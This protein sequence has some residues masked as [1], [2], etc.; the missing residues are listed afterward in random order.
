M[1]HVNKY[2]IVAKFRYENLRAVRDI[3]EEN[4]YF[5]TFDLKSDYH[6]IPIAKEHQKDLGFAWDFSA[7]TRFFVFVVLPFGLATAG[8]AFTKVMRSLKKKW[9]AEGK[10]TSLY[11]DDCII[12][13]KDIA[14]TEKTTAD[15]VQD[16]LRAGLTINHS[17]SRLTTSQHGSYVGFLIDTQ[18]MTFIAPAEKISHLKQKMSELVVRTRATPP[19]V[20]KIAGH[21]VSLSPAFGSLSQLFTRQMYRFIEAR[22]VW[23]Q[24]ASARCSEA[25]MHLLVKKPRWQKQP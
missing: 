17:K 25:G 4:D 3:I 19:D 5:A 8:H 18:E 2:L 12:V 15:M 1:Q 11:L 14:V 16:M 7:K 24:K 6:H 9:R 13:G 10:R 23:Y 20:A 22:E 21:L